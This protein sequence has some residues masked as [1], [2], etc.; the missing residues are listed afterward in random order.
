MRIDVWSDVVCPW[1]YLGKKRLEKALE[2]LD[3][4]DEV[5]VHWRAFQLD[6]TAGTEPKDLRTAIDR[7]YGPGSFDGMSKRL[8]ALGEELG[9]DYRFDLAQRVT[10][11][12]ALMLVAWIEANEGMET[13]DKMHDRLFRAYFTDGANIADP[14]NLVDWAVEVGVD[15]ELAGE[16]V[17]TNAGRD[18]IVRDLEAAADKDI[19]GVP[20]FVIEDS[21]LIPGAQDVDTIQKILTRMHERLSA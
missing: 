4:A 3:F 16:A 21:A 19:T 2:G 12:P 1:C 13:A 14:E 9:I 5:E 20:A 8:G 10:S 11:V 17:A 18:A 15:R 6:P 7:K